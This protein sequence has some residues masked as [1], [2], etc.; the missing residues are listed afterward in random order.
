MLVSSLAAAVLAPAS[1][2]EVGG[3]PANVLLVTVD[4]LRADRLSSYGYHRPTTPNV[5]RILNGGVR[6]TQARV[7]EPLTN[8]SLASMLTSLFPHE[9]GASRNGLRIR[10]GLASLPKALQAH[11]YRT[12]AYVGNWTLRDKI[13]GLGEHFE[14]YE[15]VLTR[16]RWFGVLR[17]E[18][19]GAD[20]T[21]QAVDWLDGHVRARPRQPFLLWVHYVDP[22]APYRFQK[23]HAA[24]LG[25]PERN[26]SRPDRY[27]TEIAFVDECIGRLIDAVER[28]H[29]TESTLVVFA[30][31][32]GES[33]GEHKYWGHGRHLYE[34]TL[35]IPMGLYWPVRLE[36]K[37]ISV[38]ALNIDLTPTVLRLLD[39]PVSRTF[40]GYDWT[41]VLDGAA[42]P[43]ERMT[44]YQAHRGAV[45]SKHE[46]DLARRSGL[47]EVALIE[48]SRK[49][50]VRV[51]SGA[52]RIY[53][54]DDDP[55]EKRS[56]TDSKSTPTSRLLAWLHSVYT[57]LTSADSD[58]PEPLDEETA[59]RLRELGYVE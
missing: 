47:L 53:D 52:R 34:P 1:A 2:R 6:F 25:I 54:L 59:E 43:P 36:P 12:A 30:S 20:L 32:H 57:G 40:K 23:E 33:L 19:D 46:S 9:H 44:R 11:G 37:E 7:V 48:G 58:A 31:D 51:Q 26:V 42:P 17:S 14:Q 5:D 4:T 45:I 56:L 41:P 15:E 8:P 28:L 13:S 22:H 38:S 24:R 55:G 16:R 50:I 49:E 39:L 27:D 29:L 35:R 18:A 3:K 21:D 10:P